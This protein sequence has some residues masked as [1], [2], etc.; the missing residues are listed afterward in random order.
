MSVDA[1]AATITATVTV[2]VPVLAACHSANIIDLGTNWSTTEFPFKVLKST[3]TFI[4]QESYWLIV[5]HLQFSIS[6][7]QIIITAVTCGCLFIWITWS[8]IIICRSTSTSTITVTVIFTFL[9]LQANHFAPP[10]HTLHHYIVFYLQPNI[11]YQLSNIKLKMTLTDLYWLPSRCL[12]NCQIIPA[13]RD[14]SVGDPQTDRDRPILFLFRT[15]I[16]VVVSFIS[17]RW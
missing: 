4:L 1:V 9:Y 12:F 6:I 14:L 2:V 17:S 8:K 13:R 11:K 10:T 15:I 5:L 16:T 3:F 7:T